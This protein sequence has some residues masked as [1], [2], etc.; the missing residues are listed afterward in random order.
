MRKLA[1]VPAALLVA[2]GLGGGALACVRH[3]EARA[4]WRAGAEVGR[5][6]YDPARSDRLYEAVVLELGFARHAGLVVIAGACLALVS[7]ARRPVHGGE[8]AGRRADLA[9]LIDGALVA[10][11]IAISIYSER[12]GADRAAWAALGAR[13]WGGLALAGLAAATATGGSLGLRLM[14]LRAH[15]EGLS[16]GAA[17]ALLALA[18]LPI[19]TLTAPI[20]LLAGRPR[21]PHLAWLGLSVTRSA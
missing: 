19:A 7:I 8:R 16:P 9:T 18:L 6:G 1:F 2:A 12:A 21:A 20:A 17:R 11:V 5:A 10:I 15:R 13:A 4:R 3:D 14:G